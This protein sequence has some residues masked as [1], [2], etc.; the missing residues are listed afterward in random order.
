[1]QVNC[2]RIGCRFPLVEELLGL[3]LAELDIVRTSTPGPSVI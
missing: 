3:L 1:M 2:S